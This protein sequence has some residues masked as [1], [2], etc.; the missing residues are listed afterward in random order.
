MNRAPLKRPSRPA[1]R[2]RAA[3][4][5]FPVNEPGPIEA[6]CSCSRSWFLSL[7][8]SRSM[9]RAPLK[10]ICDVIP[11]GKVVSLFPVNEPG[12]IEATR[13]PIKSRHWRPLFPVNEPGPIEASMVWRRRL[14]F[15]ALFSRSMNRAP[16]KQVAALV[17]RLERILFSR[18]MNRA[19]LKPRLPRGSR[20]GLTPSLF[21]VNEPGPIEAATP[22]CAAEGTCALFP[23]NEP[24][25]IE[26][27]SGRP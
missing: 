2:S 1:A 11:C 22:S 17:L 21:P 19:P 13:T 7:L 23:V 14:D 12:P 15:R 16:L 10:H 6:G 5:L 9:N 20:R 25:P 4:P 24:G 8:F 27:R 26:A 18:S 3:H